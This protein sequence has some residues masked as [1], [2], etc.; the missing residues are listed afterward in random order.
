M[1]NDIKK[2]NSDSERSVANLENVQPKFHISYFKC[3]CVTLTQWKKE[4]L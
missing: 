4:F 1:S 2:K 3:Y